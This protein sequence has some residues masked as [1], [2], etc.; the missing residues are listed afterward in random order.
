MA[1]TVETDVSCCCID[2]DRHQANPQS[3]K[4]LE[5]RKRRAAGIEVVSMKQK[6]AILI[7]KT[8]TRESRDARIHEVIMPAS[9]KARAIGW[10]CKHILAV[11]AA[12]SASKAA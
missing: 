1:I 4:E 8:L 9:P 11:Q 7:A 10:K 12:I 2:W 3:E 5:D 6:G